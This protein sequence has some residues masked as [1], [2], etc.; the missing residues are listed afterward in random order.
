[1]TREAQPGNPRPRLFRLPPDQG[2]INRMGFNNEGALAVAAHLAT[3]RPVSVPIGVSL[4]KSQSDA[5]RARQ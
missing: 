4:G 1:M 3:M 2:L 5:A